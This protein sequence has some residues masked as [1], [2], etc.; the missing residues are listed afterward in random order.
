MKL[1]KNY[2]TLFYLKTCI[3]LI[4]LLSNNLYLECL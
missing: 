2:I 3:I 1:C 4:T